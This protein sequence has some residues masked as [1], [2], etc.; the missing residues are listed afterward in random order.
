MHPAKKDGAV[1]DPTEEQ[2]I[3]RLHQMIGDSNVPIKVL[4]TFRWNINDQVAESWQRD[5]VLCIGDSTHR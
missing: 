2:I 1:F 5:R 4:S 3:G